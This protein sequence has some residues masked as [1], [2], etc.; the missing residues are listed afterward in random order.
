M[1]GYIHPAYAESLADFGTSRQL[2]RCGGW[3]LVRQ[4]PGTPHIDGMGCY[5][6]FFCQDWSQ[7]EADLEEI[8]DE[9]VTLALVT[10]PFGAYQP[11]YLRQCFDVVLPF[12]EHFIVDLRRPLNEI[13]SKNNR[14]KVRKAFKKVQVEK[15]EDPSQFLDEWTAL[16]ATLIERHNIQAMRAFSR[17]AF[18]KQLSFPGMV[19]LRARYQGTT[20]GITLWFMQGEVGYGHLAAF[21]P[22]GYQLR[23]SY[24]LDWYAL[25]YFSDQLRWLDFGA[26]AGIANDGTDGLSAYKRI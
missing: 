15:C 17:V 22:V 5:P 24:A 2:P 4:I 21:S 1:K 12:K 25:K 11:A 10:D 3:I 13:V 6:R 16:Y 23:A 19:M 9:L 7:L 18:A 8:G 20:V 26:G 14:K